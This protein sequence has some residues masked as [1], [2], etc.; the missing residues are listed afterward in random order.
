MPPN[1]PGYYAKEAPAPAYAADVR[2]PNAFAR[3]IDSFLSDIKRNE[4]I[5]SPFYKEVLCELSRIALQ[6]D[7]AQQNE[8][9]AQALSTFIQEMDRRKRRDSKTLRFGEKLRPLVT[10]LSQFTTVTDIAIQAG[11]KAA[12]VLY[13]GARLVLQVGYV[14]K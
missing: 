10:G 12:V 3:A 13:S 9:A 7:S 8:D 14:S 2:K 1:A 6:D 11:P 4:D 5:K